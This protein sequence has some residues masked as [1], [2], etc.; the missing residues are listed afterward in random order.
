MNV[1]FFRTL[2]DYN[3]WARDRLLA[4]VAQLS[5]AEYAAPRPLDYGSLRA[6]LVHALA[7]EVAWLER[8]QGRSPDRLL[9]ERDLPSLATLEERWAREEARTRAYLSGLA[10]TDLSRQVDSVSVRTRTRYT[11]P[12]WALMAQLANH[13]T[14]HRS[15]VAL[16]LTQLGH[17][18][19]DL[20]FLVYFSR[21]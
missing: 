3:H 4:Q 14:Q 15:E 16:V 18:P 6:T 9:D 11:S 1:E 8:W 5:E 13:G 19:G 7:A 2:F 17:S 10:E 12:L 21:R 20:D